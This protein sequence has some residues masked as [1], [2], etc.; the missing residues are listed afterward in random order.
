MDNVLQLLQTVIVICIVLSAL[1]LV[2]LGI[3]YKGRKKH[4]RVIF[5]RITKHGG[6]NSNRSKWTYSNNYTVD[7]KY[8]DS[9][10]LHTFRCEKT[11]F[12]LLNEGK[13]Y[14]VRVKLRQIVKIYRS[15]AGCCVF[16]TAFYIT[17]YLSLRRRIR[18]GT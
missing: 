6:L 12:D 2:S 5:K 9:E 14:C 16:A 15:K 18:Q 10:K 4:I 13:S 7:C 1:L 3:F 8:L 17:Y 11:V